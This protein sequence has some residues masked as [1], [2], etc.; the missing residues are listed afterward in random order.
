[1]HWVWVILIGFAAG[2]IAKMLTPGSGPGGFLLTAALGVG[3]SLTASLLGRL[4][5]LYTAGQS[6]GFIGAVIGAIVLLLI[7]HLAAKR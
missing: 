5:G 7:Y 3:G 4:T 2:L 1:M 6:A